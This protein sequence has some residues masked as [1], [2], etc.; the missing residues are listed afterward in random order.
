M[1]IVILSLFLAFSGAAYA[2]DGGVVDLDGSE[3]TTKK[4][5]GGAKGAEGN[6]IREIER[7]Y[8]IKSSIGNT[9]YLLAYGGSGLIRSGTSLSLSV[10]GDFVDL[11]RMSMAWEIIINQGLHNGRK[12]EELAGGNLFIQGDIH[13]VSAI[14]SFEASFYP[15]RR[16]GIGIRAGGGVMLIPLLMHQDAFNTLVIPVAWQ[17]STDPTVHGQP[18]GV[19]QGGPTIEYYTKLSHFSLGADVDVVYIIG[20][21][22]GINATGYLKYTF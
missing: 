5:R 17:Q 7:G 9:S 16:F 4:K 13:T 11:E 18:L 3:T 10:G 14:G 2:Q 22:L 1:R 20:F 12:F 6:I 8:F 21:D 19:V 15:S